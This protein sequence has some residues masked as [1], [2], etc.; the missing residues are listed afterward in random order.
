[1][2][3]SSGKVHVAYLLH[4]PRPQTRVNVYMYI[5]WTRAGKNLRCFKKVVRFLGFLVFLGYL[6]FIGF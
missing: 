5:I 6:D 3:E 4:R 2:S 1:M